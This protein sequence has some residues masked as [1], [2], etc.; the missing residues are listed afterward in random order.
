MN[1]Q[2]ILKSWLA[3]AVNA[4]AVALHWEGVLLAAS[5]TVVF[6]ITT[7]FHISFSADDYASLVAGIGLVIGAIVF[8]WGLLRSILVYFG[9]L[10][11]V[12]TVSSAG[13]I[14]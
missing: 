9:T 4:Q 11:A 7:F 6:F 3:S 5:S 12:G 13:S 14:R 2:P 10:H 1:T 8:I